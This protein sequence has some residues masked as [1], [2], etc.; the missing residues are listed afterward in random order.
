MVVRRYL[1]FILTDESWNAILL[2]CGLGICICPL[3]PFGTSQEEPCANQDCVK[4]IFA[5][6]DMAGQ[7]GPT[8]TIA[9]GR[10]EIVG[11]V[12]LCVTDTMVVATPFASNPGLL[13]NAC[14]HTVSIPPVWYC[15]VS[16]VQSF[17]AQYC[18]VYCIVLYVPVV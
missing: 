14:G 18:I 12:T 11:R 17:T 10:P 6:W 9:L 8:A 5:L 16:E 13:V 15:I 1:P 7:T 2:V 4:L 3:H